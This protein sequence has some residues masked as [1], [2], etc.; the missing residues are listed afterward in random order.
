FS[1]WSC[2]ARFSGNGQHHPQ[3][4]G[5]AVSGILSRE[6]ASCR[7]TVSADLTPDRARGRRADQAGQRL[8]RRPRASRAHDSRRDAS[9]VRFF[10]FRQGAWSRG[11][12]NGHRREQGGLPPGPARRP[13][14]LPPGGTNSPAAAYRMM[15]RGCSVLLIHFHSYPILS[16]TSQE[17]VREIS[18]VL[19]KHQ[20]RSRLVLVPFG[21]LQQRVLLAVSPDLRVVVYR[22][23]MLRI[24]E[25]IA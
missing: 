22:R 1:R 3:G 11:F 6:R 5:G 17:K 7:Q 13:A 16:R 18:A 12:A 19:T 10:F 14:F 9:R 25:K 8:A 23:L 2:T 20:L 21:D 24:A 4:P 15:R